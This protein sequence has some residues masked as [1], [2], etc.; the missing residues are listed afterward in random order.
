METK[1]KISISLKNES[2]RNQ[3]L[4]ALKEFSVLQL[5]VLKSKNT[6]SIEVFLLMKL[7]ADV[8]KLRTRS[9]LV[10]AAEIHGVI[11]CISSFEKASF[12]LKLGN[13]FYQYY[14][15]P[16]SI[17][18]TK[19]SLVQPLRVYTERKK[20]MK[21]LKVF[22]EKF[23]HDHDILLSEAK[24]ADSCNFH[25]S[26]IKGYFSVFKH[27]LEYLESLYLGTVFFDK[28][29][30]VRFI[31][32][33]RFL[34]ELQK[35]FVMRNKNS[36]YL[37]SKMEKLMRDLEE[38]EGAYVSSEFYNIVVL[39][40]EKL[41]RMITNRIRELNQRISF[42]QL[43]FALRLEDVKKDEKLEMVISTII[44][45]L[46]PEEIFMFHKREDYSQSD[47]EANMIYYLLVIGEG[48]S[49]DKVFSTQ[50]SIF[51]KSEG[52]AYAIIL[53]HRRFSI[54]DRL[55]ASQDFMKTLMADENRLYASSLYHPE[56]HW[57]YISADYN[58]DLCIYYTRM[59]KTVKQ[60]FSNRENNTEGNGEFLMLLFSHAM[61]K[62]LRVHLYCSLCNYL[63][64]FINLYDTWK[65]CV[66]TE[67]SLE[68][69]EFLFEKIDV[70]FF[71]LVDSFLAYTE[72]PHQFKGGDLETMDEILNFLLN[73]LDDLIKKNNYINQL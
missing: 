36:L 32:L 43:S 14:A 64:N 72:R 2:V 20:Y 29:I 49:N 53:G 6:E 63:P 4:Q 11:I 54:Q 56:I 12:Q 18:W 62:I 57:E 37:I 34:P 60:Y 38:D 61:M 1:N 73:K 39:T 50:Q 28:D 69:I 9:W 46:A 51:D 7:N 66:Y 15:H 55:F 52:N 33:F 16:S 40:E 47:A 5:H 68:K 3:I 71:K 59:L 42:K 48:L 17:I 44:Q 22:K 30:H 45:R 19:D 67:P 10:N 31:T 58:G 41:Y 65:L 21:R 8:E 24:K 27:D 13:P 26:T 70:K 23:Y 35:L 25:T